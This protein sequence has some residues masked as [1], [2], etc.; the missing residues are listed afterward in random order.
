MLYDLSEL[1]LESLIRPWLAE[2]AAGR[3]CG[4]GLSAQV[5]AGD[6]GSGPAPVRV[7]AV[8][9]NNPAL[10][11]LT[12]ELFWQGRPV[13]PRPVLAPGAI[14]PGRD[15]I[16]VFSN[17]YAEIKAQ[18][19]GLGLAEGRDF[20]ALADFSL[21]YHWF[22]EGRLVV[23]TTGILVAERCNLNCR[24]CCLL[25]PANRAAPLPT[26]AELS[27]DLDLL[28]SLVDRLEYLDLYGGEPF[29]NEA[30]PGYVRSAAR[31]RG[32]IAALSITTNGQIGPRPELI[33]AARAFGRVVFR[34]SD[35]RP[36]LSPG[37]VGRYERTAAELRATGLEIDELAWPRWYASYLE[38]AGRPP[39][40]PAERAAGHYAH[41]RRQ[42]TSRCYVFGGGRLYNCQLTVPADR[43]G[44]VPAD[45][46]DWLDFRG[47]AQRPG[48]RFELLRRY[49][50]YCP[51]GYL[52]ACRYCYGFGPEAPAVPVGYQ[53]PKE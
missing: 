47:L 28:M 7:R 14:E 32:R 29:L 1:E 17:S 16:L 21:L 27:R 4:F 26:L 38:A 24:D 30:L 11:G 53:L 18:L 15:R 8:F 46:G 39:L 22:A 5:T 44:W 25:A 36:A 35:Y 3:L 13:G 12:A 37:Q 10:W 45:P 19:E 43:L 40:V 41:C 2:A 6:C 49:L 48:G 23:Q 31:Y 52:A 34:L 50:G 33:A 51:P 20:L 42:P 9:D